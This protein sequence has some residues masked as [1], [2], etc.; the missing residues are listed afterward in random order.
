MDLVF[1]LKRSII[2][3]ISTENL[4][5]HVIFFERRIRYLLPVKKLVILAFIL[6]GCHKD[7]SAPKKEYFMSAMI[8]DVWWEVS[9]NNDVGFVTDYDYAKK[10]F[11]LLVA[12]SDPTPNVKYRVIQ[13]SFDFVPGKGRYP[14]N[15]TGSVQKDSGT[16]AVLTYKSGPVY[17]YK[18]ST[19]GYVDVD[20]LT[21]NYI[22]G[23][24]VVKFKGD[25]TDTSTT[26]ISKGS[27][28]APYSGSSGLLWPGP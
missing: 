2:S 23:R 3:P 14:F 6:V 26:S 13:I 22:K 20:T 4:R 7:D 27:F 5:I 19:E 9:A 1:M 12:G 8:N 16:I 24:F 28:V 10:R 17:S 25:A 21:K 15:N 11:S 18:W